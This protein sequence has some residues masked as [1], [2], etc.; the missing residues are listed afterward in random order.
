MG[1]KRVF[2]FVLVGLGVLSIA[3]GLLFLVGAA[4]KPSRYAVSG[5][6]LVVGAVA[7]AVGVA[8]HRRAD[9]ESPLQLRAEILDLARRKNGEISRADVAAALGARMPGAEPVL[10]ELQRTGVCKPTD[11]DGQSYF[12][13]ASLQPRLLIR[14]C[15]FCTYEAPLGDDRKVCPNCGGALDTTRAA[16]SVSGN[17]DYGMDG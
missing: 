17:D 6:A 14:K 9:T 7:A 10:E 12:L 15:R 5:V 13:F 2:A 1:M 11:R 3:L 4:G 8:L 16:R